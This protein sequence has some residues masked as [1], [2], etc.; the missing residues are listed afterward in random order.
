M[1]DEGKTLGETTAGIAIAGD[2]Y[3]ERREHELQLREI[4]SELRSRLARTDSEHA[5][6]LQSLRADLQRQVGRAEDENRALQKRIGE[7]HDG[8]EEAWLEKVRIMDEE[9]REQIKAK[10]EELEE[11]EESIREIQEDARS[12]AGRSRWS[13]SFQ[14]QDYSSEHVAIVNT[15]RRE[16]VE[17]KDSHDRLQSQTGNIINGIANG[18]S[19][20]LTTSVVSG[21][22]LPFQISCNCVLERCQL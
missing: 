4:E 11:L 13:G 9:F 22:M 12:S 19:A 6:E 17:A 16:V 18:V 10:E 7:L 5:A 15:A 2:L 21:G 3:K 14:D 20:G 1:I 8:E